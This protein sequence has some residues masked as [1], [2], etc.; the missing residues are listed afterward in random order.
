MR[1]ART[2]SPRLPNNSRSRA[3]KRSALTLAACHLASTLLANPARATD[4]Q[5]TWNNSTA[6]WTTPVNW[7]NLPAVN[8]FPNN[9]NAGLTYDATIPGGNVTLDS[10]PVT[11]QKLV[12]GG[13]VLDLATQLTANESFT[14]SGGTLSGAGALSSPAILLSG[15]AH[16]LQGVTINANNTTNW[17]SGQVNTG[18]GAAFHNKGTFVNSFAGLWAF[19]QGGAPALFD[20]AGLFRTTT[21]T[22]NTTIGVTFNNSGTVRVESGNLLLQGAGASTGPFEL[23]AGSNLD[24]TSGASH[25]LQQGATITGAG[26]TRILSGATLTVSGNDVSINRLEQSGTIQ[27]TGTLLINQSHNWNSGLMTGAGTT[28]IAPAAT[29]TWSTSIKTLAGGRIINNLGAIE[30]QGGGVNASEGVVL[31]NSGTF[32]ASPASNHS[33]AANQTGSQARFNNTG[34]FV[35]SGGTNTTTDMAAAFHN[36]GTARVE[37]GVLVLSGGGT[38]SG[39]FEIAPAAQLQLSSNGYHLTPA[40]A[41]VGDGTFRLA[42]GSAEIAGEYNVAAT[43]IHN[44]VLNALPGSRHNAVTLVT[45]SLVFTSVSARLDLYDNSMV[46]DYTGASAL[47]FVRS[48]LF[49]GFAAGAWN[50]NGI[51]SS[52]AAADPTKALGYAEA[53]AVLGISGAQTAR[54]NAKTVDATSVLVKYVFKGDANLDGRVSF[55]DLVALAQNYNTT[56]GQA[57]WSSGDFNF[58]GNINFADLVALAQNYNSTLPTPG[59]FVAQFEADLQSA[60]ANLPEPTSVALIT[61]TVCVAERRKESKSKRQSRR[62]EK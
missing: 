25:V 1:S 4:V 23:A 60:F 21:A 22:G 56:T 13:G 59:A 49:T 44:A 30:W 61:L 53:A 37:A 62:K 16:T 6:P 57:L 35:K 12:M 27:G 43:S 28:S 58:D 39:R 26:G 52:S 40:S 55:S 17:T 42:G 15:G 46:V 20:N 11:L 47:P 51:R 5:S 31:N 14:W 33:F 10:Q 18:S 41:V 48:N 7:N 19:N 32:T 36:S 3:A 38:S 24:F 54:F 45:K 2:A 29:S 8:A 9:G 50:G 34:L